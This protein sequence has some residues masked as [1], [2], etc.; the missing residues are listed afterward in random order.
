MK[1]SHVFWTGTRVLG[2]KLG[3]GFGSPL[4]VPVNIGMSVTERCNSRCK[5]C[6]VWKTDI[7]DELG[8]EE[9]EKIFRSIG[10]SHSWITVAEGEAFLSRDL[11][12]IM[13]VVVKNNDPQ[14][15]L[16][17]TN[18][19]LTKNIT[20]SVREILGFYKGRLIVNFSLDDIGELHDKIRGVKGNFKHLVDSASAVGELRSD[21][22]NL[23]MGINTVVSKYNVDHIKELYDFVKKE[24]SPDSHIFEIARNGASLYN[25]GVSITPDIKKY[26]EAM[27]SVEGGGGAKLTYFFRKRYYRLL[28][29]IL[30]DKKEVIPCYSGISSA[31]I[32]ST[33][34]VWACSMR[35]NSMGNL[36]GNNY[37]FKTVWKSERAKKIRRDI[38]E[39]KCWCTSANANYTN[40]LCN[41]RRVIGV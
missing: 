11:V 19:I 38:K 32:S 13:R 28:E 6:N 21:F 18:G 7:K 39:R 14:I 26:L 17:P 35:C 36:R 23:N 40:M 20:K 34:D 41:F 24:I 1:V 4:P 10:K 8:V 31:H 37:D 5:T 30:R 12:D 22:D 29:E 2:Y 15:L 9:W 27:K 16:L 25:N 3:R 33:G